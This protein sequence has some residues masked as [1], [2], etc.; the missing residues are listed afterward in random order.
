M[1][2]SER[3]KLGAKARKANKERALLDKATRNAVAV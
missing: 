2:M 3:G 1:S